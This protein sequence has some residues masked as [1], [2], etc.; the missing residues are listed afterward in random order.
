MKPPFKYLRDP[1]FLAVMVV[2]LVNRFCVEPV[3]IGKVPFFHCY[4]NDLICGPFWLPGLL[5]VYRKLGL[6]AHDRP[7][8]WAEVFFHLAIWSVLFEVVGPAYGRYFGYPTADPWDVVCYFLGGA[9]SVLI[10]NRWRCVASGQRGL[11][12][13]SET[14]AVLKSPN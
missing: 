1:L 9:V 10:W 8:G 7:P 6:R 11:G 12:H 2:Y 13:A 14:P 3:T 5:Y 4:V